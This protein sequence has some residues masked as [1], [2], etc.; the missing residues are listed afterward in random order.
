MGGGHQPRFPILFFQAA[1]SEGIQASVALDLAKHRFNNGLV[2]GVDRL[3]NLGSELA[4]HPAAGI[5][6]FRR[7]ATR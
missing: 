4:V 2:Q 7:S 1:Q 6:V 5:E 3:A